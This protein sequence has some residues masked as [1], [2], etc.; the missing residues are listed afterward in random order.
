MGSKPTIMKKI[1]YLVII[2]ALA[3]GLEHKY[4]ASILNLGTPSQNSNASSQNL[5]TSPLQ[6]AFNN[7]QS[8]LQ[9]QYK[10]LVSKVLPDDN[11]G[12]RHQRFIMKFNTLSILVAHNIDLA[13]KII[14]LKAGDSI[15]FYGEYEWNPKGGII[16]WTHHD[17]AGRHIDGWLKHQG[18][19]YQ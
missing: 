15:E 13:P 11:K 19:T 8:D 6:S 14:G 4:G 18:K 12:S 16:H 1:I 17:P 9:I 2:F 10:G 3:Y 5:N 7:R